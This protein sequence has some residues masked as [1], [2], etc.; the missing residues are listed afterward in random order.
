MVGLTPRQAGSM[1]K[2]TCTISSFRSCSTLPMG[3]LIVLVSGWSDNGWL[4]G[5]HAVLMAMELSLHKGW[6]NF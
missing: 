4:S 2:E 6:P 5:G 1:S 3:H